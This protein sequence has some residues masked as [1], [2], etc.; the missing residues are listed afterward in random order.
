MAFLATEQLGRMIPRACRISA[1]GARFP[2]ASAEPL[3]RCASAGSRLSRFP[4]G[5]GAFR[6][7]PGLCV[8]EISAARVNGCRVNET[9]R[10]TFNSG[11]SRRAA[12]RS[13]AHKVFSEV[14]FFVWFFWRQ[15]GWFRRRAHGFQ[16]RSSSDEFFAG[17]WDIF[18]G[19]VPFSGGAFPLKD[20]SEVR[21]TFPKAQSVVIWIFTVYESPPILQKGRK[22]IRETPVGKANMIAPGLAPITLS[23]VPITLGGPPITLGPAPMTLGGPP[24]TLASS[25]HDRG[26]LTKS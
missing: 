24:I 12:T 10:D 26:I 13:K 17:A 14:Q 2:R 3:R 8:R 9:V 23:P 6:C 16:R 18:K 21:G 25:P 20:F 4:A 5:V 1:S 19:A 15:E 11:S 7:N 22:R